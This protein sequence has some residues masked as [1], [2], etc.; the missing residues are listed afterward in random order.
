MYRDRADRGLREWL[1]PS[2]IVA[3]FPAAGVG[4]LLLY[5]YVRFGALLDFGIR[6]LA[7]IYVDYFRQG[8]FMRYDHIPYNIWDYFFRLPETADVA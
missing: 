3:G 8:H 2:T 4:L 6:N 5:N 7:T 1:I